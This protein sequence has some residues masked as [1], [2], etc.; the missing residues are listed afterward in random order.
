MRDPKQGSRWQRFLCMVVGLHE[1]QPFGVTKGGSEYR[2]VYRC[3]RC[4]CRL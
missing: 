4:K 2:I 1:P 3:R